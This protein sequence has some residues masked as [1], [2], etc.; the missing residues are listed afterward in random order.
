MNFQP[1][2]PQYQQAIEEVLKQQNFMKHIGFEVTKIT[3]GYV[4]GEIF[5]K[6][7]L[8]QQ[9]GFIHGGVIATLADVVCGI[10]AATLVSEF[11]NVVTSDLKISFLNPGVGNRI[12]AQGW[13]IKAGSRMFFCEAEI[14]DADTQLLLAKSSAT[15]V[16]IPKLK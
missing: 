13:V 11:E 3:P 2:N 15:M 14:I 16:I 12:L 1:K 7:F 6:D 10:A 9:I 5:F 4:E 8:R